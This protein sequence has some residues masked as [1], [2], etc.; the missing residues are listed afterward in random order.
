MLPPR[1]LFKNSTCNSSSVSLLLCTRYVCIWSISPLWNPT[2]TRSCNTF[3]FNWPTALSI[4]ENSLR[5]VKI[6]YNKWRI[7]NKGP[8]NGEEMFIHLEEIIKNYNKENGGRGGQCYLQWYKKDGCE[9]QQLVL[10]ICTPLMS[11]IHQITQAG[12]MDF[13]DDSWSLHHHNNPVFFLCTHHPTGALPLAVWATSSQSQSTI[14][15]CCNHPT[16]TW[17]WRK[18]NGKRTYISTNRRWSCT[19]KH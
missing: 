16:T 17:F 2:Y 19:E 14:S 11:R 3:T 12:E 7:E 10:T 15:S 9:E 4:T 6:I 5:D 18:R 13:M 8:I 1:H